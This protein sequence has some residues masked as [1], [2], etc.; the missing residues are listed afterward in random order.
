[1]T[2][3]G[4]ALLWLAALA[5]LL[6][7]AVLVV[8]CL[9]ALAPPRRRDEEMTAERPRVTV[10]IP[11]HN[12][13]AGIAATLQSAQ[14]ELQP[15]D[16][17]VVVADNCDDATAAVA[18]GLGAT[19]IERRDPVRRGKGY[20]LDYGVRYLAA[21]PPDVVVMLD[22]DCVVMPGAFDRLARLAQATGRPVQAAYLL[23]PP[24]NANPLAAISAFAFMVKN[25]VRPRGL[26][27]LGAP[28]LLTGSGMAFPWTVI[29]DAPLAGGKSA[30]DMRLAVDLAVAGGPPLFHEAARVYSWLPSRPDA[31]R[32]QRARWEHGHLE[33]LLTQVLRLMREALKQRRLAL[34]AL[35]L[36]LAVPPLSLLVTLWGVVLT[37]TI[38]AGWAGLTWAPAL[39]TLAG[40]GVFLVTLIAVWA[41]FARNQMAL[42]TLLKIPIY[43]ITKLPLYLGFLAR[44]Q[45]A[46][47][48]TERDEE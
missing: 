41:R 32:A 33:T 36:E 11:A 20:A 44:R 29:R 15:G 8:E 7:L 13:A 34:L 30:E 17:L 3:L 12:E 26:H 9:A 25:L 46:S 16:T 45:T 43:V 37:L 40:G 42:A 21:N 18:R 38:V 6:P 39:A 35:A 22:A 23:T 19:V 24:A 48:R 1:M 4:T 31:A 28:C 5:A 10:L 2:T 14:A 27:R 47:L